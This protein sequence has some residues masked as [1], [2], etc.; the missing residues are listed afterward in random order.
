[1]FIKKLGL[2]VAISLLGVTMMLSET[3]PSIASVGAPGAPASH[4][5]CC[6]PL[7]EVGGSALAGAVGGAIGGALVGAPG[8][9]LAG[10]LGAAIGGALGDIAAMLLGQPN[11]Q[12]AAAVP[13]TQFDH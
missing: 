2:A 1:M 10:A 9:A 3:S 6:G 4:I 11:P 13:N 12:V 8:G 7:V 5:M